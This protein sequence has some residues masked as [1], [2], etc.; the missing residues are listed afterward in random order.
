MSLVGRS[1]FGRSR[2]GINSDIYKPSLNS[3]LSSIYTETHR[4]F[5]N[6]LNSA[7]TEPVHLSSLAYIIQKF[8][9]DSRTTIGSPTALA[10][11]DHARII[12]L[13][14]IVFQVNIDCLFVQNILNINHSRL[15]S[16]LQGKVAE[17]I[18][19][20]AQPVS[21][22]FKLVLFIYITADVFHVMDVK[23]RDQ[24]YSQLVTIQSPGATKQLFSTNDNIQFYMLD[25]STQKNLN[26]VT[27]C[28]SQIVDLLFY[29]I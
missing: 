28:I 2:R 17:I 29:N 25:D 27:T 12:L 15:K 10:T 24:L 5:L 20:I 22:Q 6:I 14:S 21:A 8:F 23:I 18:S 9:N 19:Y 11:N 1:R 16:T 7:S 13:F 4:R 3:Q 26:K